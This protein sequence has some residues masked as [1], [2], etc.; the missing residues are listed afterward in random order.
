MPDSFLYRVCDIAGQIIYLDLD[1]KVVYFNGELNNRYSIK[2]QENQLS[3][4]SPT[5]PDR[6][7]LVNSPEFYNIIHLLEQVHVHEVTK[8]V[9]GIIEPPKEIK[10]PTIV[11]Q[12]EVPKKTENIAISD[13]YVPVKAPIQANG[14]LDPTNHFFYIDIHKNASTKFSTLFLKQGWQYKEAYNLEK[15]LKRGRVFCILRDPFERYI[16]GLTQF[17]DTDVK[18]L[19][20]DPSD[21]SQLCLIWKNLLFTNKDIESK[22]KVMK[23]VFMLTNNFEFDIHTR[24][25]V[26]FLQHCEIDKI[27]FFLL[28]DNLGYR[29]S[30]YFQKYIKFVQINNEKI[31]STLDYPTSVNY[32]TIVQKF[33]TDDDYLQ[34]RQK[35]LKYLQPDFQLIN[36]IKVYAG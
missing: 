32:H 25:Q 15:I 19:Q 22:L 26:K 7:I 14:Y 24:L 3:I 11:D 2:L 23:L 8:K 36:S 29:M 10:S 30:K 34:Q 16:S 21:N 28:D 35:L 1:N 18:E 31:H 20:N 13:V 5:A 6:S 4:T 27:D 9:E 12:V 17:L 33:L